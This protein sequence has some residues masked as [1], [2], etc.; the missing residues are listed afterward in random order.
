MPDASL[1][2]IGSRLTLILHQTFE[3]WRYSP[4][5]YANAKEVIVHL[6]ADGKRPSEGAKKLLAQAFGQLPRLVT[7]RAGEGEW[8]AD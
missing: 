1:Q 8:G 6:D 7:A 5:V 4:A 2:E 3:F